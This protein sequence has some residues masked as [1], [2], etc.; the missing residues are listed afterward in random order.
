MKK[1]DFLIIVFFLITAVILWLLVNITL[2]DITKGEVVIY[3]EGK[4]FATIPLTAE[5]TVIVEDEIG[6][7]NV[8]KVE[9][10]KVTMTE[11]SCRDQ[12]C[13]HTRP[14]RKDG[15]SIICLP[16]RVAVEVR[17][18]QKNEIDGVSE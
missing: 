6:N 9:G 8:I 17:S 4:V 13:V 12:I 14:A 11:A 1:K 16:N 7:R 3:K 15:Q 18:T 5:E 10:G 2:A